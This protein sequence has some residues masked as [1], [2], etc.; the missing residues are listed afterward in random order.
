M[1]HH[2]RNSYA[3]EN[4]FAYYY[5]YIGPHFVAAIITSQFIY[6]VKLVQLRFNVLNQ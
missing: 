1:F 5:A 3:G 2:F 6:L 4:M